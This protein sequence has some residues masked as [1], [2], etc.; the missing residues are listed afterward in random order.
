MK[1]HTNRLGRHL[2]AALTA[3]VAAQA[4]SAEIIY[5]AVNWTVPANLDGLYINVQTQTTGSAGSAVAGWDINPYGSSTLTWFNA[6][7]TG[8]MRFP[9][10]TTGSAGNLAIGTL[11]DATRSFGSG[12][13]VVG[14]AAGN[15]QLNSAN[16]FGFRFVAADGLTHYG[17]GKFQVGSSISGAD[18]K[19]TEIAYENVAGVGIAVGDQGGPPPAYDPCAASNPTVGIG[20]SNLGINQTAPDLDVNGMNITRANYYKF[21]ASVSGDWTFSTCASGQATRMALLGDCIAGAAVL[22][23]NDDSCG[24]SSSLT[25]SLSAGGVYY[26][27]VGGEGPELTSPI[28]VVSVGPTIPACV[29]AGAASYGDN[30][31]D[32]SLGNG[33]QVVASTA[34]GTGS[35]TINQS[36]WFAFTPTA[37]GQ[38][39]FKTCGSNGDTML[40]IGTT[41]PTVGAKF[42]T[43][44][45][46]DDAPNCA[47]GAT[48]AGNL[49]SFINA[50]NN[51]A[52][53]TY[54]GFPLTQNLVAGQT[55][56]ICVGAYSATTSV[57]GLL[58]I[59][60][61]EGVACPADLD[62]DGTVSGSDLGLLLGN[63]GGSG[64]GDLDGDGNVS[65]SDLGLLL[66]AWGACP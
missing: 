26:L 50:T 24:S 47:S 46:N 14:A 7:G 35:A 22:A 49:A 23:S 44:A 43:I 17:W 39:A 10:A 32:T 5:S 53:G 8:M 59:S 33:A 29:N 54:A 25:A 15:W 48:G 60:G 52:T 27:V 62:G 21:T 11:V 12:A 37:T 58:N 36:L 3:A 2:A 55:Y 31:M 64:I 6:T 66:G 34:D 20:S 45:Y 41:C 65:G 13:V 42:A 30:V 18:R 16:Y 19:I 4:A 56:Y 9:G 1:S 38:F 51:G 28:G 63:W 40:A 57:Q 61:P